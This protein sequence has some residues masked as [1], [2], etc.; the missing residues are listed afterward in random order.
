MSK[1]QLEENGTLGEGHNLSPVAFPRTD[2]N[3]GQVSHS[4]KGAAS[5]TDKIMDAVAIDTTGNENVPRR[6]A[7]VNY[8]AGPYPVV[9]DGTEGVDEGDGAR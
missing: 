9:D 6:D 7:E 3:R 2:E 4:N 5:R 1:W 8:K